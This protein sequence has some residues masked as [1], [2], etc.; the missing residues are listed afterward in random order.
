MNETISSFHLQMEVKVR[1]S[2]GIQYGETNACTETGRVRILACQ[3]SPTRAPSACSAR[4]LTGMLMHRA[5]DRYG[6][7]VLWL[8]PASDFCTV[9]C[10]PIRNVPYI[11]LL[12]ST[13]KSFF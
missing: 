13:L 7:N 12:L 3:L 1:L 6:R 8:L 5:N 11:Y 4:P 10:V 9:L 2:V